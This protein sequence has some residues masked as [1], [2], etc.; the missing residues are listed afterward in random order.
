MNPHLPQSVFEFLNREG[1]IKVFGIGRIDRK[2]RYPT[3]VTPVFY[4]FCRNLKRNLFCCLI[5]SLRIS[6][7]ESK[8]SQNCMHFGIVVSGITK[9]INYF[10]KRISGALRPVHNP[11]YCLLP[12]FRSH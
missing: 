11:G 5:Y 12:V 6:V 10:G 1:I 2:C 4:L 8:L 7:R 3:K 9:D